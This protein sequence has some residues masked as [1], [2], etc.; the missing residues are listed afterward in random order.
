M[1]NLE[2]ILSPEDILRFIKRRYPKGSERVP[3]ALVGEL[4]SSTERALMR[5]GNRTQAS[6]E[7]LRELLGD[8]YEASKK[9]ITANDLYARIRTLF[10]RMEGARYNDRDLS[11]IERQLRDL[12]DM[13]SQSS[14][15]EQKYDELQGQ[16]DRMKSEIDGVRPA[17]GE[18]QEDAL[19]KFQ[20]SDKKAFI[21]M[22]FQREL[23]NVWIG[24]IKPAC[25]E[26]HYA[27]LRVDE[28]ALSSLITDDIEQ[29]SAMADVIIVDVSGNNPNVMFE[30]GWA[31]AKNK[32]P[33][34]I[35]Q[36][37]FASKVAFDVRGIRYISYENS[38]IG[39]E[40]LKRK[41]KEF[42]AATDKQKVKVAKK[43]AKRKKQAK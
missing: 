2:N 5:R 24:A 22:P 17:T 14:D 12:R 10:E 32:H 41:L 1:P 9:G 21:I 39:V 25:S 20:S 7:V 27:S 40:E 16:I 37:E 15:A 30:F 4:L 11:R 3:S 23:N 38:W 42:L 8:T 6:L 19:Q 26:L 36:G 28:I 31:L 13:V 34:V 35:C 29:Y 33:I 18:K 43:P